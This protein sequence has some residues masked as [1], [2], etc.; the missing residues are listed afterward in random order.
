MSSF[1]FFTAGQ[2]RFTGLSRAFYT[3]ALG[4]IVVFDLMDRNSFE[5]AQKWKRD[6]DEKIELPNGRKIPV[7]LLGNKCDLVSKNGSPAA[8]SPDAINSFVEQHDFYRYYPTSA[9]DGTNV[10]TAIDD[11]VEEIVRRIRLPHVEGVSNS[12]A[13]SHVRPANTVSLAA[14]TTSPKADEGGCC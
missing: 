2:D 12:A 9:L 7:L 3:H 6:I 14:S 5:S 8:V 1:F 10:H 13:D 11:L 4:A